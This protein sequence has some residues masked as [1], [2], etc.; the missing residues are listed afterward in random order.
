MQTPYSVSHLQG[1]RSAILD[2]YQSKKVPLDP[3]IDAEWLKM[4]LGYEKLINSL[5]QRSLMKPREGKLYLKI[6]GFYCLAKNIMHRKF[7]NNHSGGNY[8]SNI[9]TWCFMLIQ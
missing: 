3:T 8:N 7:N 2:L 6:E 1:Y 4:H 5:R 9:F